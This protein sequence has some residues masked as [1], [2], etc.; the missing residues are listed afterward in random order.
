M[1]KEQTVLVKRDEPLW[2]IVARSLA[3]A[4]RQVKLPIGLLLASGLAAL[5]VQYV[6]SWGRGRSGPWVAEE[7]LSTLIWTVGVVLFGVSFSLH[8]ASQ[9][10]AGCVAAGTAVA[11]QRLHQMV[12]AAPLLGVVSAVLMGTA[13]GILMVR[14][15]FRSPVLFFVSVFV[16]G[17][18]LFATRFVGTTSRALYRYAREQADAAARAQAEAAEAQLAALQAQLNPHFLFN[19]LNTVAALVRT[20]PMRAETTVENVAQVLRR[21]LERTRRTVAPLGEEI[22]YLQAYLAVEKERWGDRLEASWKLASE[23]LAVPV[24]PLTLQPL[25]ENALKHGLSERIEGGR[26][27]VAADLEGGQLVLS[28]TDDGV[29]PPM[30]IIEGTGLSNLRQRLSTLYG[31]AAELRLEPRRQGMSESVSAALVCISMLPGCTSASLDSL[32]A[33]S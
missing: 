31:E 6:D 8:N 33:H 18:A 28:V 15:I 10:A 11:P 17:A 22:E 7:N 13:G 20:D 12:L 24:P 23:A 25:V 27:E 26:I 30:R 5:V 9:K 2:R 14:G 1:V 32:S 21:T 16:W 3:E 29:G 19:A 4:P